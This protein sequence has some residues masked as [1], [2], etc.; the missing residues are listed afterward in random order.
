MVISNEPFIGVKNFKNVFGYSLYMGLYL[1]I[2][3]AQFHM[4]PIIYKLVFV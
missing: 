1:Q 2:L 4:L 3:C